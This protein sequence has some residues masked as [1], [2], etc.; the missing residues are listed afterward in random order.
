MLFTHKVKKPDEI[1]AVT[2]IDNTGRAQTITE[3]QNPFYYRLIKEFQRLSGTP[4]LINTSFNLRGEPIV[5]APKD[6]IS[7]FMRCGIDY[8]VMGDYL[9]EKKGEIADG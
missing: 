4:A 5:H 9:I 1:P 6:A 8:L 7:T 3:K 2:H